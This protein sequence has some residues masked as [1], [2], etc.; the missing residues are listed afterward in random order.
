MSTC[1][2]ICIYVCMDIITHLRFCQ[3]IDVWTIYITAQDSKSSTKEPYLPQKE[4]TLVRPKRPRLFSTHIRYSSHTLNKKKR[5][6]K[7]FEV[8]SQLA[9]ANKKALWW[10]FRDH[11]TKQ[12]LFIPAESSASS[13]VTVHA[14]DSPPDSRLCWHISGRTSGLFY[15]QILIFLLGLW[16]VDLKEWEWLRE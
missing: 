6:T 15:S 11:E 3:R 8:I 2:Y 7:L 1:L 9:T 13:R 14:F 16:N 12:T 10:D 5:K 4:R